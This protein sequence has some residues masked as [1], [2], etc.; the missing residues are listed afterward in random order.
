M[1]CYSKN[2]TNKI[3]ISEWYWSIKKWLIIVRPIILNLINNSYVWRFV[4]LLFAK[5][6]SSR[7]CQSW[8][9]FVP[10]IACCISGKLLIMINILSDILLIWSI[11]LANRWSMHIVDQLLSFSW[12]WQIVDPGN[13]L[14]NCQSWHFVDPNRAKCRSGKLLIMIYIFSDNLLIRSTFF[15]QLLILE[16]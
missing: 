11:F 10:N 16:A 12:S 14:A 4:D 2:E 3:L 6:W 13:Y 15:G 9:I 7:D 5:C 1:D 8:Q